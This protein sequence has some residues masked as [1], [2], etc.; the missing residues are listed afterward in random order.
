MFASG[1][2]AEY[3]PLPG[4]SRKALAEDPAGLDWYKLDFTSDRPKLVYFQ[5]DLMERD[6][7]PV[8]VTIH[9]LVNGKLEEFFEGEDP[10][11]VPHE[12]QALP[13]N[14]FTTRTLKDKGTYY[15][16]VRANHPEYK[17]R[18]RVYDPPPYTDPH[19]AVRTALDFIIGAGDSWHANTPA[20]RRRSRPCFERPPGDV[21]LRRL[22]RHA[23][24]AAR[25]DVR[26]AQRLPDRAAAAGPVS[27]R[28]FLQQ[29]APVLR[30][31]GAGSGLGARHLR[32]RQRAGPHVAPA[33]HL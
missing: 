2:D 21:A 24:P 23:L 27:H 5:V 8:N 6:Q 19:T 28:A 17:L 10:V 18:T 4:A 29:S 22:P 13:G 11:T 3:I 1:D 25:P 7:I 33:R 14:K 31:R 20:P 30:L 16:A 9:R 32:A 26:H 12:V 15:I